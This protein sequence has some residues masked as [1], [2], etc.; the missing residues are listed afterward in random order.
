M[1]IMHS[2]TRALLAGLVALALLA[3][4][5]SDSPTAPAGATSPASPANATTQPGT[6]GA[7]PVGTPNPT[8]ISYPAPAQ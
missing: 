4:C 2:F 7:Y 1:H 5:A 8:T 6:N 3:G